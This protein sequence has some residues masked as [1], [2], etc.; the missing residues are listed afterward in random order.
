[1]YRITKSVYIH[2]AHCVN[3]HSGLC[4]GP[5]G[6][7]WKF[8]VCL[9]SRVLDKEGFVCDFGL[10][11]KHILTP[12]EKVL[13][14]AFA[15]GEGL[16]ASIIE[17]LKV[18]GGRLLEQREKLYGVDAADAMQGENIKACVSYSLPGVRVGFIDGVKLVT[19]DFNP[20]SERLAEW[21]YKYAQA[22]ADQHI[23]KLIKVDRV[24]VYETMHPVESFA[25][26]SVD[27]DD[28]L[29]TDHA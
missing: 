26:F 27:D 18:I 6:H 14:H 23:S 2:F 15:L 8:E 12:V 5:H 28:L 20:T 29:A 1:M 24:R 9:K 16:A 19:F 4:L 3:G 17:P 7:T 10:V 25:E 11:K 21:F 22:Q 13:D